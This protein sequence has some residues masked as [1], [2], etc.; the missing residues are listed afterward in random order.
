MS[1]INKHNSHGTFNGK[2]NVARKMFGK[3]LLNLFGELSQGE[4]GAKYV[5]KRLKASHHNRTLA[6]HAHSLQN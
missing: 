5:S 4:R 2:L 3:C 1:E 6:V